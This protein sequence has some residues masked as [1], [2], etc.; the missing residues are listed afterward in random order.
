VNVCEASV[1]IPIDLS[2]SWSG[3]IISSEPDTTTE[4]LAHTAL[5]Y[6]SESQLTATAALPS[7]LLLI[8]N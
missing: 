2:E 4:V 6:L 5:T 7:T 8:W 1:M 3:S